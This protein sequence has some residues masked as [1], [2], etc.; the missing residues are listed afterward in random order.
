MSSTCHKYLVIQTGA[1]HAVFRRVSNAAYSAA[2]SV[3][4]KNQNALVYIDGQLHDRCVK[5]TAF[6]SSV[7]NNGQLAFWW[8]N[9]EVIKMQTTDTSCISSSIGK[10]R[11]TRHPHVMYLTQLPTPT[12]IIK[13]FNKIINSNIGTIIFLQSIIY[14]LCRV[15]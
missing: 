12:D 6:S 5:Y 1:K 11:G 9:A 8:T 14:H 3:E 13:K 4:F 15:L 7:E 10:R 2:F